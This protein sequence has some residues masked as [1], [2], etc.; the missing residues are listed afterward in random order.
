M[1][2]YAEKSLCGIA[3]DGRKFLRAFVNDV[4]VEFVSLIEAHDRSA[5]AQ[6]EVRR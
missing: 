6:Q 3:K 5:A 2:D 1:L 4:D